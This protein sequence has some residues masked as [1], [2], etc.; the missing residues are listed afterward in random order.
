MT[1]QNQAGEDSPSR[2]H[3]LGYNHYCWSKDDI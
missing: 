3:F 2:R 1:V